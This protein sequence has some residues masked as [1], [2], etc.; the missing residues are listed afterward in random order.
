MTVPAS[1]GIPAITWIINAASTSGAF[2]RSDPLIS[3]E[4]SKIS[5]AGSYPSEK[6]LTRYGSAVLSKN[7]F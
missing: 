1:K 4:P 5:S 2:N 3:R 7:V 6:R